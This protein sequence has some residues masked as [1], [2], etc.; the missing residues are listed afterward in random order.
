MPY[1]RRLYE[2]HGEVWHGIEESQ[3]YLEGKLILANQRRHSTTMQRPQEAFLQTEVQALQPL[4]A[5]AYEI[6]QF[7]EGVVRQDGHVR[8]ANRYYSVEE[9]HKG[10]SVVV[11]GG[12]KQV[13][14]YY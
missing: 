3:A 4:P 12:L 14:I 8:F 13:S 5:W 1:C 7:H 6:E 2:A 9:K 10:K 11:L